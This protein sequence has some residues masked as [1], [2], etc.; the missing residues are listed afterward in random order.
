MNNLFAYSL[1]L[2]G[3]PVQGAFCVHYDTPVVPDKRPPHK[4]YFHSRNSNLIQLN[5][6]VNQHLHKQGFDIL[7]TTLKNM[8]FI[9]P[10]MGI[11]HSHAIQGAQRNECI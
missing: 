1:K 8:N 2:C 5:Q 3:R 4:H 6:N 10:T 11:S 9:T 7:L